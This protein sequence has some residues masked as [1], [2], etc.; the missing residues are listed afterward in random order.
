[1]RKL[2]KYLQAYFT[3]K[4]M[5]RLFYADSNSNY[6][7]IKE[8]IPSNE[9]EARFSNLRKEIIEILCGKQ[10]INERYKTWQYDFVTYTQ[11][12]FGIG[13]SEHSHEVISD[14]VFKEPKETNDVGNLF[15][16]ITFES[17]W[18]WTPNMSIK[19]MAFNALGILILSGK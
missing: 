3:A 1:M 7:K 6:L 18:F 17:P 11:N 16:G 14:D 4:R 8:D 5:A 12:E 10:E 15:P 2:F 19:P 13:V 9:R